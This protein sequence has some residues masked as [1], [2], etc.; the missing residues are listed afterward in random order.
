MAIKKYMGI[1]IGGTNTKGGIIDENGT[2]INSLS[3]KTLASNGA[4]FVIDNI[5]NN[6]C[7]KL[8]QDA[9]LSLKD[10]E[11]IGLGIPGIVNSKTGI[12]TFNGN[13]SWKEVNVVKMMKKKLNTNICITND[14]NAAALGEAKFGASK[15][16]DD[17]IL[18]TL[19][20]GVGGGII[21]N[22]KLFE[23][24]E[25]AGAEI[26]HMV[27]K[28]DGDYCTCGRYGCF[29][30]YSSATGLIRQTKAAM[31]ANKDSLMWKLAGDSL[32]NVSGKTAFECQ[33]SDKAAD[34]VVQN[35]IKYLGEGLANL[36][37][38]FRPQVIILGGGISKEGD[39]LII[40]LQKYFDKHIFGGK[41]GPQ[42]LIKHASLSNNAGFIGAAAL[43]L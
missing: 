26:G 4:D 23:G 8:L 31:E 42:V 36:A 17:S 5:V 6:L 11:G 41:L 2:I 1:D 37:S 38:I 20:T 18:V 21:I 34:E 22:G 35:Y 15:E 14:A 39:N 19:G 24:N 40:P 33:K 3:I 12:V 29:E 27:V 28:V 10:I 32:D 43:L 30:S 7:N 25:G 9:K 16:Y 13:L